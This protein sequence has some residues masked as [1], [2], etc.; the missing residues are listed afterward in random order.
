MR[1][2]GLLAVLVML[3]QIP[4]FAQT[5]GGLFQPACNIGTSGQSLQ[6]TWVA[7]VAESGGNFAPFA[8][9]TF[10]ADGSFLGV[11]RDPSHSA[12]IGVWLRVGDRKFVFT[13]TF[14]THD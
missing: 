3:S 1:F 11:N 14:F 4:A 2:Y 7:Q 12:H 10:Y 8:V 13:I 5:C 9:D 6:G